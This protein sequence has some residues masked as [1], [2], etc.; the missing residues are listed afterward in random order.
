MQYNEASRLD[1]VHKARK[2]DFLVLYSTI[3]GVYLD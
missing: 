1:S 2:V 3:R